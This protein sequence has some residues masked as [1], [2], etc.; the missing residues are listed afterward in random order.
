MCIR[1]SLH[2]CVELTLI[3]GVEK[4][5]N[6]EESLR[7]QF[8]PNIFITPYKHM[9]FKVCFTEKG[10]QFKKDLEIG[11]PPTTISPRKIDQQD[12]RSTEAYDL[13]SG[14]DSYSRRGV[15]NRSSIDQLM[16]SISPKITER[17]EIC[18]PK[19][20]VNVGSSS[21]LQKRLERTAEK[22]HMAVDE[23]SLVFKGK[24]KGSPRST[25][26]FD[27][28]FN[29]S[30]LIETIYQIDEEPENKSFL[31]KIPDEDIFSAYYKA[32]NEEKHCENIM[33]KHER[34]N[35]DHQRLIRNLR[36]KME[37]KSQRFD[38]TYEKLPEIR[39][40]ISQSVQSLHAPSADHE[41]QRRKDRIKEYHEKKFKVGW[42][43]FTLINK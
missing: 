35:E 12:R 8:D 36:R 43:K 5:R 37:N 11:L 15:M 25:R 21:Y 27:R 19:V 23:T 14:N 28:T 32:A 22:F 29:K 3:L 26:S 38:P 33:R 4:R 18:L 24:Y 9:A 10:V 39:T 16:D 13:Y 30:S 2:I 42:T 17:G 1:D 40:K 34:Q 6:Q 31:M 20:K 41:S 7:L